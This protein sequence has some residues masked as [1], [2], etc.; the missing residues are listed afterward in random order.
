MRKVLHLSS[1]VLDRVPEAADNRTLRDRY[2][3]AT[4]AGAGAGTAST[5]RNSWPGATGSTGNEM[6]MRTPAGGPANE[7]SCERGAS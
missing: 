7:R 6:M 5:S 4:R 1:D 2:T 3:I